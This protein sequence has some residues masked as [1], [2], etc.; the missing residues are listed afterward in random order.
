VGTV[1][2]AG[3]AIAACQPQT[4]VIETE[5]IVKETVVVEQEKVVKET[6]VVETEKVVK[7]TVVVE[8]EKIVEKEVTPTPVPMSPKESPLVTARVQAGQ[9]PPIE[10]RLPSEPMVLA[11]YQEI[12]QFG[13]TL[14]VG[15]TF[16]TFFSG[17]VQ[18][19]CC[20]Q[21]L[22][23]IMP[24]L[25]DAGPNVAKQFEV[26]DEATVY[27]IH[28]RKGM[29]WSDGTPVTAD[30]A[31][32][33]WEDVLLNEDLTPTI[34]NY[35]FT[36]G[37]PMKVNKIDDYTFTYEFAAPNPA[38]LLASIAHHYGF[39]QG[40]L[41]PAEYCKPFHANHNA[42][43]QAQAEGEG[44]DY[45]YQYLSHMKNWN[46][47]TDVPH[48]MAH[49][50]T[51]Q[52]PDSVFL[53]RNPYFF[54]IDTEGNQ[55]PYIDKVIGARLSDIEMVNAKIV[56]GEVDFAG[57]NTDITNYRAYDDAS[58]QG[59]YRILLWNTGKGSECQYAVNMTYP[60]P[61]MREVFQDVRF[62]RALSVAIDRDD[63]NNVVY[64]GRAV[65]RAMTIISYSK[66]YKPEYGEAWAY[67]DP[68]E[69]NALLDDMGLE[70]DAN[71]ELRLFPDGRPL[72]IFF[73]MFETET[74]K[75]P[76]TELVK[77]NWKAIGLDLNWKSISRALLRPKVLANEEPM[78]LWHG[79]SAS[80]VLFPLVRKFW[81]PDYGDESTWC[82]LWGQ[83]FV[84]RGKEGEEPP[85]EIKQ[86][87][88]WHQKLGATLEDE[89]AHKILQS[90]ADNVWNIGTV[91]EAP[92]PLV[93]NN[94]L[95]NVVEEGVWVWDVKWTYPF[96]PELW[97]FKKG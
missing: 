37:E 88:E 3:V 10:D 12:G 86:L 95:Q 75:A 92:H 35:M 59:D 45:W 44:Y 76:I 4:V 50:C 28:L 15:T 84:T 22:L 83:W 94:K 54:I 70:W 60:D 46:E 57:F 6:V 61:V 32:F 29:K 55:L 43:A 2:A 74:P 67:Y 52:T 23:R 77:D 33:W 49:V 5:K 36:G 93:V 91:G 64:F 56:G 18:M 25:Q 58:G 38:F 81:V 53:E 96:Y 39:G 14:R 40:H 63:I 73:D 7:E 11:P 89:W 17:D 34:P 68:D 30:D 79:G 62:R 1:A 41:W 8:T 65:P 80:D 82:P 90:Q 9:I 69:A 51:T 21:Q 16:T 13:G 66:Y 47:N 85:E 48:Y 71:H 19:S 42:E 78:S 27:T 72:Q 97:F 20:T 26:N 87:D 24:N 31:V